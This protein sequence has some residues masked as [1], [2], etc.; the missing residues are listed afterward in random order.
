M[1]YKVFLG[2]VI[3]NRL[4][5]IEAASLRAFEKLAVPTEELEGASCCPDPVGAAAFDHK[6]WLALGA[7]NLALAEEVDADLYSLCNGCVETLKA[8]RAE[9]V[10]EHEREEINELLSQV[11]KKYSG[12]VQVKHFVEV[13]YED[14][15]LAKI[16]EAVMNPLTGLKVACHYGCHYM[17]PSSI[18]Q[19]EDPLNPTRLDELVEALGATPVDYEEKMLCCG[20]ATAKTNEETS[21]AILN[22]KMASIQDAGADC[23]VVICPACFLQFDNY[24]RALKKEFHREYKIPVFFYTELLA[25]AL[26]IS[27]EDFGV[28]Y[29]RVKAKSLLANL[30]A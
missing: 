3:P 8:V 1:A 5:F 12:K 23:I 16:R 10:D 17:R 6:G 27:G 13:L 15:G 19:G 28:K 24:Q 20:N 21:L 4:P 7:R 22:T 29:H 2:C 30:T 18:I 25:L 14:V 26:G 11:N 9:L